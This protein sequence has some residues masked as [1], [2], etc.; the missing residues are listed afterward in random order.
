MV[1]SRAL[2][3][4]KFELLLSGVQISTEDLVKLEQEGYR[5][6]SI[7]RTGASYGIEAI[8]EDVLCVNIPLST[9]SSVH[10][11]PD[12]KSLTREG[13]HLCEI[14]I[15]KNP[16]SLSLKTDDVKIQDAAR[17]CFD[18]LGITLYA[19]C[20]FKEEHKGCKFCGI[21]AGSRFGNKR[22]LTPTEACRLVDEA[23]I[24]PDHGIRHI[25]LSGGVLPGNDYGAKVFAETASV[26][27]SIHPALPIYIMMP[28]PKGNDVLQ[29]LID[30]GI[31]EIALNIEIMDN[32]VRKRTIPGKD[33]IG[34][35]RY[36]NALEY[37]AE[38][39]PRFGARSLLMG[40]VESISST[41]HGVEELCTRGIMPIISYYRPIGPAIP[42]FLQ[43]A[44]DIFSLWESAAEISDKHNMVIGPTCIPC[45]NNV[46]A[47]PVGNAFIY[48]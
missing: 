28:P 38:H 26:L 27:K 42:S 5:V 19:G 45:Q 40:G 30:S 1:L 7:V 13:K 6:P 9:S 15:L 17:I 31:D 34:L 16:I 20:R 29:H 12:F 21:D 8:I 14:D 36:F 3:L 11:S 22:I 41:L 25:L 43:S 33:A 2:G 24:V 23:L 18:R 4:L 37:L 46:I 44:E 32:D 47:L 10:I 35:A 48:Y 39:L